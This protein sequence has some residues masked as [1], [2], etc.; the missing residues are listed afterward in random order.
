MWGEDHVAMGIFARGE[1]LCAPL[2]R[3]V[4]SRN[5]C[6]GVRRAAAGRRTRGR[7]SQRLFAET[8]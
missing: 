7:Q 3:I 5:R 4:L 8:N 1:M 2:T 6:T